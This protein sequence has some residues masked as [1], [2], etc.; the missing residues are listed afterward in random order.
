MLAVFPAP[1]GLRQFNGSTALLTLVALSP[2]AVILAG[3]LALPHTQ[4]MGTMGA[5]GPLG[6]RSPTV[7]LRTMLLP[8]F[9]TQSPTPK[10]GSLLKEKVFLSPLSYCT[11]TCQTLCAL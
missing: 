8:E 4:A 11:S 3:T 9:F 1:S 2:M 10:R 5:L 6:S 7:Q